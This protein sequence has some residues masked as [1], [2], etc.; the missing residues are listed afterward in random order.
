MQHCPLKTLE[1]LNYDEVIS[2][3]ERRG[4]T[5]TDMVL[6]QCVRPRSASDGLCVSTKKERGKRR[7]EEAKKEL[8]RRMTVREKKQT[9]AGRTESK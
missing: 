3:A 7:R 8:L 6:G 2:R 5:E 4:V 1:H 9:E